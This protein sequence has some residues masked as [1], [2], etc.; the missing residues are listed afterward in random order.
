MMS[1]RVRERVWCWSVC[2]TL[3]IWA[4]APRDAHAQACPDD[5]FCFYVPPGLPTEG[6][7]SVASSR[8]FDIVLSSPARTISGTYSVAGRPSTA[9]SVS[10]GASLRI[11]LG[12]LSGPAAA[13]G[14]PE[15]NGV[16]LVAD[17]EDLTVDHR[18]TYGEEQY[19]ETIKRSSVALGSRFRLGGY[20]LDR[21]DRPDAGADVV[22]VYAPTG[23]TINLAAPPGA[24]LPF[25]SGSPAAVYTATLTAGQTLSV[26]TLIGLDLDGAL[27]TSS[28]PVAVSSGGRGW[29]AG[30]CGD[31]GM[32]GLVPVS[33]LGTE[34][35]VR[36]PTGSDPQNNESRARVIADQDGTEVRINGALVATLAAGSAYSFQPTTLSHIK[37]TRPV[38]VWMNGS[39]NGCELDTVLIPPIAFA[40][41]LSLLS[42]DF[43]VLPSDQTPPGELAILILTSA[44]PSIRL[45][46]AAPTFTANEA[47]PE[48][49]DLSYVRFDVAAGDQNVRAESDFQA[50]LASRTR[51]SGLLAYYNP[52]RIPGCGDSAADPG[53][54]C[55][56]GNLRG[57]DGCSSVCQVEPGFVCT[58]TPS[59][60]GPTCG[61]G[62]TTPLIERC[63]D[64]NLVSGDGCSDQCRLEVTLRTPVDGAVT[65]ERRPTL[66]GTA[67]PNARLTVGVGDVVGMTVADAAGSWSFTPDAALEDGLRVLTASAVDVRGGRSMVMASITID[68]R[69]TVLI[70]EP[71]VGAV[72]RSALP[73]LRGS[74][75]P[76]ASVALTLDQGAVGSTTA[77]ADGSWQLALTSP[78]ADG[79]HTASATSTDSAGNSATS[80]R[81]FR[82]DTLTSV[83]LAAPMLG[84]VLTTGTPELSGSGEPGARVEVSIDDRVIDTL[85][86]DDA[87]RWSV[88]VTVPLPA[89][90]HGITLR[91]TDGVGNMASSSATFSVLLPSAG[92]E[93]RNP[94]DG[95]HVQDGRPPL[96]GVASAGA[97]VSVS[98]DDVLLG[99][100]RSTGS[101]SW[102]V[103][104][105]S[106]LPAGSHVL[107]ATST[108]ADGVTLDDRHTFV[109]DP[110]VPA[111]TF[112]EPRHGAVL[113]DATPTLAGSSEP[114]LTVQVFLDDIDV[115]SA[116]VGADGRWRLEPTTPLADG[117]VAARA[118]VGSPS[119]QVAQA[120]LGFRIDTRTAVRIVAPARGGTVGSPLP[121]FAGTSEARAMLVV[122]V[123][124]VELDVIDAAVDGTWYVV[125]T[126]PLS[127]GAHRVVASAMDALGNEAEDST[128]FRYD[129]AQRD[130]DGDGRLDSEECV[131]APCVDTDGDGTSDDDDA[132]DDGDGLPSAIECWSRPCRDSDGDGTPDVLDPD[133]DGDGRP[134]G[135]ERASDGPRDHDG[136]GRPDHLD[137]DD[138]GD[139][140]STES[141][142]GTEPCPDTDGDGLPDYLDAD[143]DGDGL[144]S[145][146]ERADGERLGN[147]LDGDGFVS[148][149]DDDA[150]DNRLRDE[151]DGLSDQDGDQRPDYVDVDLETP[152]AIVVTDDGYEVAGGAGCELGRRTA[153][154]L[155][156]TLL[157]ALAALAL[158]RRRR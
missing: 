95:A 130:G 69:T 56:D 107:W 129:P 53:E 20:S 157:L 5:K 146:R 82:T 144:P 145:G 60:C 35:V 158:R 24:S 37:T 22:L 86:V 44:V 54:G 77:L 142:C 148:W 93:I 85:P 101:G 42:L 112:E 41:A 88:M 73:V 155:A 52:F 23:G 151:L 92:L 62:I 138:D 46:G 80:A 7:H 38:L 9:F 61:N 39:L 49:P 123:D 153:G 120:G 55:D 28:A 2:C 33:A 134:S 36:L 94:L 13:Y 48:R 16:F 10:P 50:L 51:P 27:L 103:F 31:D 121:V 96:L 105:L 26:R 152:S 100:F 124:G 32:D 40:P 75:E 78:L 91:T 11:P 3:L 64:G 68:S 47:V 65:R 84:A 117:P 17:S 43:N 132:D 76:G 79:A 72:L 59:S 67:D 150:N 45:N 70:D 133:D 98:I 125:A 4:L 81:D 156:Q 18:E 21:E 127:A 74:A 25:W 8:Q 83:S 118:Q 149:L 106:P 66:T 15:Q 126:T 97:H 6:S 143:D 104:L 1:R 57:G 140:L 113:R 108:G 116:P 63:D 147:D 110:A 102:Q 90:D 115:G 87:G 12:G 99:T 128:D 136:D 89:G 14:V 58:G 131:A 122:A 135:V 109:V 137:P 119:G 139:G 141:E 71:G 29:S 19:S 111:L 114:G 154:S 30:G 34:Y